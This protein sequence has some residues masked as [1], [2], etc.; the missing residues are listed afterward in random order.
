[1]TAMISAMTAMVRVFTMVP[2]LVVGRALLA[3]GRLR[4]Y[5]FAPSSPPRA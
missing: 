3:P 5:P 2:S 1:M 4:A